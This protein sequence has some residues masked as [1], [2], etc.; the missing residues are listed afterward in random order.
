MGNKKLIYFRVGKWP[1]FD[2]R[3]LGVSGIRFEFIPKN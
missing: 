2:G 3:F 1:N